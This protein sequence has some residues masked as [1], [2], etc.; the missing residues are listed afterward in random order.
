[1]E[2]KEVRELLPAHV[3]DEMDVRESLALVDHVRACPDCRAR[4][5]ALQA[6]RAAV[7]AHASYFRAPADLERRIVA[8]LPSPPAAPPATPPARAAWRWPSLVGALASV[9]AVVWSAGL[10]LGLPTADDRLTD[11]IV[12]SHVR[13]LLSNRAVDVASSDQHTVK[14][15]YNG[16][17]DFSP[18]VLDLTG[19]GFPLV[20]GRLD[21]VDH[22]P[23]AA[24]VYRHAQHLINV[25]VLPAAGSAGEAAPRAASQNGFHVLHW[26]QGGMTY[27]AISDVESGQL[28]RLAELLRASGAAR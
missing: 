16:K 4:L 28:T 11:E 3:D 9:I 21:Y 22:R 19:D 8:A 6:L 2:C 5:E 14:P 1:M 25:Y 10:Y 12:A 20:G 15:W 13:S 24:L 18:P 23:V 7:G 17:L 27:W 26:T